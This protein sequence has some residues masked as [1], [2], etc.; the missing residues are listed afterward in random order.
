MLVWTVR[1]TPE[2]V[3]AGYVYRF[4]VEAARWEGSAC[5]HRDDFA[6]ADRPPWV[7]HGGPALYLGLPLAADVEHP[8]RFMFAARLGLVREEDLR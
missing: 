5:L 6:P 7:S 2:S 8:D 1:P 4:L 3:N